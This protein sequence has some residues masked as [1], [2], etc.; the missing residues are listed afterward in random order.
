MHHIELILTLTGGLAAALVL[1]Y[2]THRLGLSPLLGYLLAG[3]VV[4]PHT[5]GFVANESI[6]S[7][8]AEVGV[9][10]L[11]FGVGLQFH[12][13]ELLLVRRVA[14]PGAVVQSTVATVLGCLVARGF[15]WDWSAGLVFGLAISVASTVVLLRVLSDN[16]DLHTPAGHIAVGW[17][18]VEDLLTVF[19]LVVL[20]VLA[21]AG[22]GAGAAIGSVGLAVLKIGLLVGFTI[23]VGGRVIPWLLARVAETQSRELFTLTVLVTALGIAVGAAALFGVSMALGAFLAGM[24]VGRSDFSLRAATDALPMRDAFA[25]LF[26]VSVG[27]LFDPS[28]L[29]RNPGLVAAL[30][31]VILVGKPLAALLLVWLMRYPLR[32]ALSVAVALA[33]IGE[34]SFILAALGREL[35]ILPE[36]ATSALVA[37]A[38]LSIGLNPVLYRLLDP[39]EA[40]LKRSPRLWRWLTRRERS[41]PEGGPVEEAEGFEAVVVGYGPVGRTLVRLLRDSG[42][43]PTVVE[44]NLDT[45]RALRAEGVRVVY[46]DATHPDTLKES[47]AGRAVAI[48][49]TS[50]GMH[51]SGETIRLARQLNPEI[52]VFARAGYLKEVPGL[53]GAGAD[54]VFASEGEV[55]L[56]MTEFLL[57]QL[58]ATADQIDHERDRIRDDLFGGPP[59]PEPLLP[60]SPPPAEPEPAAGPAAP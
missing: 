29:L 10:L 4:G 47:G 59:T 12:F 56:A 9:I 55:A 38:I 23:V 42:V 25:V 49:L 37:A 44:M 20:P 57:R 31:G 16:H 3:I 54:A 14:V 32:T 13:D 24:V 35:K 6:A 39:A 17:L 11:M 41:V 15:G 7:Q 2:L 36:E 52:R 30:L 27:M 26:F 5:P 51:G 8:L 58:G 40:R 18:V 46:G 28:Y 21:G 1:G 53:R 33:Q 43:V 50:A 19:V 45:V 34:F 48:Y 22:A 60:P